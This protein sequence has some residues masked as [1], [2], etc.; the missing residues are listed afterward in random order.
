MI[1]IKLSK[2]QNIKG[3]TLLETFPGVGLVGAMTGSYIIEKLEMESIGRLDSD[4]F[5]QIAAVH[6][7]VP[8]F[9]ARIYKNDKYKIVI[10]MAEF[11]IPPQLVYQLS[12]EMLSFA[13]K[14]GI[15]RIV[16][17]GGLPSAKP[18]SNIYI[19][20]TDRN[21]MQTATKIGIK[22]IQDGIISGVSASLLAYSKEYNIPMLE[23]LVEVNPAIM[24]PKYAELAITGLNKMLGMDID[25]GE[26]HKEAKL[27]EARIREMLKKLKDHQQAQ[28]SGDQP[29]TEQSMY[30]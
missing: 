2:D 13:R 10:F 7:S 3:Y 17:V 20:S 12:Q 18:T 23:L 5:P 26:L 24:D 8:M 14:Y 27:V 11:M 22:P 4:M 28:G 19:T 1:Q 21:T 9:P 15:G 29:S 25:L 30:A 16:S 6:N